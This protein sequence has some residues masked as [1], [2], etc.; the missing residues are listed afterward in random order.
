MATEVQIV[1]GDLLD[2]DVEVIVNAWNRNLIPWWMLIPQGVSKAIKNRAGYQPFIEL[3]RFGAIPLGGAVLTGAG[4]LK[5]NGIVHVAG[6]NMLW[7]ASRNSIKKSVHSAMNIVN[8]KE[9]LSVAF[10]IIGGGTGGCA[11]VEALAFMLEAFAEVDSS[12]Q[13]TVVRFEAQRQGAKADNRTRAD[14]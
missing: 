1:T 6:I 14:V 12:A 7:I 9:F 8:K 11:E 13:V 10:P 5:Y 4:K 3:G 2:Q